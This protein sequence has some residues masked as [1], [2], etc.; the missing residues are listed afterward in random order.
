M[1]IQNYPN[2]SQ[3]PTKTCFFLNKNK[4]LIS[5]SP[6]QPQ[7]QC[8]TEPQ[9]CFQ[10]PTTPLFWSPIGYSP[11]VVA[12]RLQFEF[13]ISGSFLGYSSFFSSPSSVRFPNQKNSSANFDDKIFN[14][15]RQGQAEEAHS[16]GDCHRRHHDSR[17][18]KSRPYWLLRSEEERPCE[19]W[20]SALQTTTPDI[21]SM[22]IFLPIN[23]SN[24]IPVKFHF[25]INLAFHLH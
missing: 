15:D 12:L 17:G 1:K 11:R 21:K 13:L 24:F 6:I 8:R 16:D 19:V 4:K 20:V 14:H 10:I 18:R 25:S 23:G 2:V 9:Y 22:Q 5:S 7:T 3:E